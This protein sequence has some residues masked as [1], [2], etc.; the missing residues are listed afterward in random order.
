MGQ[1]EKSWWRIAKRK[2][3][4]NNTTTKIK[5]TKKARKKMPTVTL[6]VHNVSL[7]QVTA[8]Y[9]L[10]TT[11]NLHILVFDSIDPL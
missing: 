3:K 4:E 1:T 9:L 5:P 8:E 6:T 11:H 10:M 7:R 2:L